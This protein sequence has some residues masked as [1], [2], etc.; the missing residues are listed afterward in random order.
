MALSVLIIEDETSLRIPLGD[1]LADLGHRVRSTADGSEGLEM[2]L[3]DLPDVVLCDV[4][5]P[6]L[7][8]LEILRRLHERQPEV[9]FVLM[10]AYGSVRDAVEA[11]KLGAYE[12]LTKPFEFAQ[13]NNLL[14]R[15]EEDKSLRA[16]LD[17]A[18]TTLAA[19]DRA[20]QDLV[21]ASDKMQDCLQQVR[22][23]ASTE[24]PLLLVGESG[25]GKTVLARAV[26]QASPRA[27]GPFVSLNCATIPRELFESELFGHER[28]AFTG[29]VRK[30]EGKVARARSG[31]L[32]LDEIGEMPLSSQPKLLHFLDAGAYEAVGGSRAEQSDAR[33]V[34]ATNR[35]L[36]D[37]VA[38]GK[39]REDL[40]YRINAMEIR[41]PPLRDRPEDIPLLVQHF[42]EEGRARGLPA[43]ES[44]S[45]EAWDVIMHHTYPGNVRELR[46]AVHRVMVVAQQ[47]EVLLR[48]LPAQMLQQGRSA[49]GQASGPAT[50]TRLAEAVADFERDHIRRVLRICGQNRTESARRLGISRKN[51][52]EKMKRLGIE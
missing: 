38:K 33:V 34:A 36:G 41:V 22:L 21:S 29:A 23:I 52:W 7:N 20:Q 44:F 11:L 8:G 43:P 28:G 1:E 5:L 39:F 14:R 31:T 19:L 42:V 37:M 18:R 30:K 46:N 13:L 9:R 51:L 26:H 15:I 25:T 49:G 17:K 40:L 6:G 24:I 4:R 48:H 35:D 3:L 45:P 32:F 50:S 12:Y 2:A 47:G 27:D 16:E 10:T